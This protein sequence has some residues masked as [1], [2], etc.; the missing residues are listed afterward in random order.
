MID[1]EN[2]AE[3]ERILS[4]AL[5]EKESV[6]EQLARV[7]ITDDGK[8][9]VLQVANK[10]ETRRKLSTHGKE[11]L[12]KGGTVVFLGPDESFLEPE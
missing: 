10:P 9:A 1:A 6:P 8:F 3:L 4:K 12:R 11:F 2:K 5:H 7:L